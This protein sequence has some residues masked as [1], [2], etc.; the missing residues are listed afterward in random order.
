MP[1][2][3]P[4]PAPRGLLFRHAA[5]GVTLLALVPLIAVLRPGGLVYLPAALLLVD[6][7]D[8]L[9]GVVARRLGTTSAFGAQLDRTCDSIAHGG[10][11]A[12]V[13]SCLPGWWAIVGM[14]PLM[15]MAV[16]LTR[17]AVG[18]D[19]ATGSS[20]N[21]LLRHLYLA[22]LLVQLGVPAVPLVPAVLLLH[23]VTMVWRRPMRYLLRRWA[24][25]PWPMIGFYGL[26]AIPLWYPPAAV[27][28]AVLFASTWA[29]SVVAAVQ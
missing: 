15:A 25:W 6:A 5:N 14:P 18:A 22:V 12:L 19:K 7:I 4:A 3:G 20:T 10:L 16:R 28:L 8:S 1:T 2:G 29:A 17:Q 23:A 21:E 24:R 11:V 27:P 26:L 13:A 9:D